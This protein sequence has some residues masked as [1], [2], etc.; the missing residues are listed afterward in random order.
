M[1][2]TS[3]ATEPPQQLPHDPMRTSG[4]MATGLHSAE[5]PEAGV[6]ATTS[7]TTASK[8]PDSS[9]VASQSAVSPASAFDPVA[10]RDLLH[11]QIEKAY[12]GDRF[13]LD[14]DV[15]LVSEITRTVHRM[16][17]IGTRHVLEA[18]LG[19]MIDTT[20]TLILRLQVA[21][22]WHLNRIDRSDGGRNG[23]LIL[24][25]SPEIRDLL[26]AMTDLG[27]LLI[28]LGDSYTKFKHVHL[29]T[30]KSLERS[31]SE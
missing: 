7:N 5:S 27:H 29:L 12:A 13:H 30:E 10:L 28:R 17:R 19:A 6:P 24:G 9:A 31:T 15:Q 4:N 25:L 2:Q 1:E 3:E 26:P 14:P 21:M 11:T 16:S 23:Q 8:A 22:S 20:S 18:G